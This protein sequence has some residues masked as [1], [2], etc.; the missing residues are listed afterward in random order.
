MATH[1]NT[2]EIRCEKCGKMFL[3][4]NLLGKHMRIHANKTRKCPVKNCQE[5]FEK[6]SLVMEHRKTVHKIGKKNKMKQFTF[7]EL[8]TIY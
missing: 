8:Y 5:V 2:P 7:F 1:R 4:Q 6:W 3:T